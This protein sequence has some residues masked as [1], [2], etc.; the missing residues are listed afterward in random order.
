M[1]TLSLLVASFPLAC[2]ALDPSSGTDDPRIASVEAFRSARERGDLDAA[3][4]LLADDPRVW[5]DAKE[6]EGTAWTLEGG[7]WREWDEHFRGASVRTTPWRSEGDG[8]WAV[9]RETNDY[10]RLTEGS[11]GIWRA[12]YYFDGR[13][14]IAGFLV[15]A[16]PGAKSDRGRRHEFEA[17]ARAHRSAEAEYLMPGGS[18]DPTGD[19]PPRMRTLL[20]EWRGTVGLPAIE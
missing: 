7:R 15:S 17:W 19:R 11:P 8:V 12:T 13:G 6:G 14:R 10:Y 3:R 9:M 5:F 4:A 20:N 1:R 2:S 18:I 16:V